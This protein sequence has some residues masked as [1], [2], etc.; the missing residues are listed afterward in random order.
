LKPEIWFRDCL[1]VVK[2]INRA[3]WGWA[4]CRDADL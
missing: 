4:T 2:R 1:G 3:F